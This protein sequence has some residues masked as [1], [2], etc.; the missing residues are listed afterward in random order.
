MNG[1][2]R[3]RYTEFGYFILVGGGS[4]NNLKSHYIDDM[5][6]ELYL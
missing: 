2:A 6:F 5:D 4:F 3:I 1:A